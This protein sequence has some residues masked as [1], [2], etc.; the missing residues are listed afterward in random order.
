VRFETKHAEAEFAVGDRVQFTDTDKKARIYNGN[1]GTI[2][3]IDARTGELWARLDS[4]RAVSW[5]AGEFPGFR[6]AMPGRSTR[7][8]ARPSTTPTSITPSTSAR[9]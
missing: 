1:V 3:G 6:H 9:R 8:R 2:T 4:G 5:S 7:V